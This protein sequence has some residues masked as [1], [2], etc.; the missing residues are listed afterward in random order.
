MGNVTDKHIFFQ[1]S[2]YLLY[3]TTGEDAPYLIK[4]DS[5]FV[6]IGT[7]VTV[8]SNSTNAKTEA[9]VDSTM[10]NRAHFLLLYDTL[11]VVYDDNTS[12]SPAIYGLKYAL[13]RDT[14]APRPQPPPRIS[15]PMDRMAL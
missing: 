12:G 10:A 8:A 7:T 15:R 3:S 4:L 5:N 1:N 13:T 14:S 9:M 6:Q 2:H 11:Y